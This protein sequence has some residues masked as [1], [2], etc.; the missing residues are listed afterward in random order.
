ME[1]LQRGIINLRTVDARRLLF[2]VL[3]LA[4]VNRLGNFEVLTGCN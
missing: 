1:S 4:S 3:Q 2:S